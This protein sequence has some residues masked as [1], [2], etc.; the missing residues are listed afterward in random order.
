[1]KVFVMKIMEALRVLFLSEVRNFTFQAGLKY[2]K[3]LGTTSTGL[4]WALIK[5]KGITYAFHVLP[6]KH[7]PII[8]S[9]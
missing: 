2:I 7:S 9:L 5:T 1:M 3:W 8:S 4:L 6:L